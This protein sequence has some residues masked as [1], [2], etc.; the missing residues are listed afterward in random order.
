MPELPEVE[1]IVRALREGRGDIPSVKGRKIAAAWLFWQRTL[2]HPSAEEF[3]AAIPDQVISQVTRRGKLIWFHLTR[4]H[5]FLHLRMSGDV[6]VEPMVWGGDQSPTA[7]KHDRLVIGFSDGWGMYFND[8]RKF[9]RA[10]LVNN[11]DLVIGNLG[12]EPLS[13]EFTAG[14]LYRNLQ[15]SNRQI[16][17]LLLDQTFLAGL[18]NI[19]TDEA[20]HLAKIHP[21]RIASKIDANASRA[22][23]HSIREVLK[24][25]IDSHGAS[26]DW[27]YKGG[28][29]Q[30]KFRVYRRTGLPCPECGSVIQR[31]LVG[32]RS[33]HFCPL[34]QPIL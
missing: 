20:L 1:T 12:L 7:Q 15:Q 2:Q 9:G 32:Q 3:L 4:S 11:P 16:K 10:W 34:C 17:T 18:G 8:T 26:I 28:D 29:F 30:N 14:W 33:T 6:R 5:L 31:I 24:S 13:D 27:V 21:N 22:L 19:Y 23:W 25:G